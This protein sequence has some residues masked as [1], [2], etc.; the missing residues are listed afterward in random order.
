MLLRNLL[1]ERPW[2]WACVFIVLQTYEKVS[3]CQEPRALTCVF[4]MSFPRSC[5]PSSGRIFREHDSSVLHLWF[6]GG[7]AGFSYTASNILKKEGHQRRQAFGKE[8]KT[9]EEKNA[10]SIGSPSNSMLGRMVDVQ[11]CPEK[12]HILHGDWR[13]RPR[14]VSA[15]SPWPTVAFIISEV[16]A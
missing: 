11:P 10:K 3:V 12:C 9:V 15:L 13:W 5:F 8:F 4:D 14:L 16:K 6:F 2:K 7:L 1:G